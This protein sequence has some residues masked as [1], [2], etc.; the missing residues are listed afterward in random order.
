MKRQHFIAGY[1]EFQKRQKCARSLIF[2]SALKYLTIRV[3]TSSIFHL[4]RGALQDVLQIILQTIPKKARI[5][6]LQNFCIKTDQTTSVNRF[7]RLNRMQ[8]KKLIETGL[9]LGARHSN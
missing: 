8:T 4:Q 1:Y 9:L 3:A 6:H 7:T 2:R 5:S